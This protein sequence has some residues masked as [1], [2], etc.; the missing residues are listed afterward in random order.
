MGI[1][2][3]LKARGLIA[4]VTDEELLIGGNVVDL[5]SRSYYHGLARRAIID[6]KT[7]QTVSEE[8][9]VLYVAMTRARNELA[10]F[11]FPPEKTSSAFS[12]FLF[13]PKRR[14]P[15][16]SKK[17][18]AADSFLP[19]TP[20]QHSAY[21]AGRILAREGDRVRIRFS[22]GSERVFS[23]AA[24]V[25]NGLLSLRQESGGNTAKAD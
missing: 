7:V 11:T 25:P 4:Q 6:R 12:Q 21:G 15:R 14:I 23:L 1:Y 10:V 5:A 8:L 16:K 24:A 17:K 18:T 22:S 9:R 13:R 19:G 2:E 3:E 20:V